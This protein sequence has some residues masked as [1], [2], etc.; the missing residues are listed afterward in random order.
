MS[1]AI[2]VVG[3]LGMFLATEILVLQ[4]SI[5]GPPIG[6]HL[7]HLATFLPGYEVSWIGGF[8]GAAYGFLIG[9]V[10]GFVLAVLWNVA[11]AVSLGFAVLRMNW[12][13]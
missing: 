10:T 5:Q 9:A 3:A 4:G 6:P 2:G 11:Q 8:I 1:L 13:D 12:L 7:S